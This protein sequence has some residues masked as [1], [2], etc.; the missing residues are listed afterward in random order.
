M[1]RSFVA[2]RPFVVICSIALLLSNCVVRGPV[3]VKPLQPLESTQIRTPVKAHLA[4]GSTIVYPNGVTVANGKLIGGGTRYD[5]T[6]TDRGPVGEIALSDVVALE[7]FENTTDRQTTVL[8][9]GGTTILAIV[10][11]AALAVAIFG[12]CPTVYANVDGN[13]KL[14]A[15]LFSYSIAPLFEATDVDPLRVKPRAD[16]RVELHVRNEALE[17][18]YLNEVAI[19]EIGHHSN[20]VVV[21]DQREVP[22]ALSDF[23]TPERIT[24]RRQRDL[25]PL[26]DA[27][28]EHVFHTDDATLRNA[29]KGDLRDWIDVDA[30]VRPGQR[31]AALML[32]LRNSLLNT[33]LF[34]DTM[35]KGAGAKS[36][37]WLAEDL[38][39]I[40]PALTLGSW[41]A[42]QMGM[43][44]EVWSNGAYREVAHVGDSGPIAWKD[45]AVIVPVPA[46]ET[47]LRVRLSFVADNWR[48]DQLR[49]ANAV[50]RPDTTRLAVADV[51]GADGKSDAAAM[52][53]LASGDTQ[54]LRTSPGEAFTVVF[55]RRNEPAG[56]SRT[57]LLQSRGYYTEWIRPSWVMNATA[58]VFTPGDEALLQ[59]ISQWRSVQGDFERQ[60]DAT[61]IPVR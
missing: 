43:R 29:S 4:D 19:L 59:A 28:D 26:L 36:I 25:H 52:R 24:D 2:P 45:M 23:S 10:G 3:T 57:F 47:R 34:Y 9:S 11:A 37:D 33:V 35:L 14:E 58:A 53:S 42:T 30:P 18:H 21:A 12:S 51:I 60:F 49:L 27:R 15:E 48:I 1:H 46:G 39:Q 32:T 8:A 7:G 50:R 54:Y 44:V 38:S 61:R 41:Y 16:R 31:E 55:D 20:E 40:Q 17:T 22:V 56:D 6:L 13:E 5:L